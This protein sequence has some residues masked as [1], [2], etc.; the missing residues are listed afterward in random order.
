MISRIFGIFGGYWGGVRNGKSSRTRDYKFRPDTHGDHDSHNVG[1]HIHRE[2][3]DKYCIGGCANFRSRIASL[4]HAVGIGRS[5]TRQWSAG[6]TLAA[7]T[8][9]W[10]AAQWPPTLPPT[11]FLR[12]Q[13]IKFQP[14]TVNVRP[15]IDLSIMSDSPFEIR[16]HQVTL[17][18]VTNGLPN[19]A[20]VPQREK[21][22]WDMVE[23]RL[24]QDR[25]AQPALRDFYGESLPPKIV[26]M[27]GTDG[28]PLT[29]DQ[30]IALKPQGGGFVFVLSKIVYEESD[31]EHGLDICLFVQ[32]NNSAPHRC[33]IGHNGPSE[34]RLKHWWN[35]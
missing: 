8:T 1:D 14:F 28:Q 30:A 3:S 32:D 7:L 11:S 27:M 16:A 33:E 2:K 5:R 19:L 34:I 35:K 13:D 4:T 20:A 31:G 9:L 21:L 24:S 29:P 15:H 26:T 25:S 17:I 6:I 12:Y 22:I 23:N 18:H 10:A